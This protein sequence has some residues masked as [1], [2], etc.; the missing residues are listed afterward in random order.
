MR[1]NIFLEKDD[2]TGRLRLR[3]EGNIFVLII[4]LAAI[5]VVVFALGSLLHRTI[6]G[7]APYE[8]TVMEINGDWLTSWFGGDMSETQQ[9]IVERPD[10]KILTRY[11]DKYALFMN[12][13]EVGDYVVKAKGFG[14]TPRPRD[15]ET[16]RELMKRLR[17]EHP[18]LV[19]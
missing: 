7:I 17:Q 8:G 15:K 11:A 6:V 13:V 3:R 10:G 12:S 4:G 18:E 16:A 19:R 2:V 1:A 5:G 14:K 9:I